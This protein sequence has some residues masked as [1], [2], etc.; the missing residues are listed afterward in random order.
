MINCA[1]VSDRGQAARQIVKNKMAVANSTNGYCQANLLLQPRQR[2]CWIKKLT[3]G[4]NS[5]QCK[6]LPQCKHFDLR[7]FDKP[8][9][10]RPVLRRKITT[11]K[12]LPMMRPKRKIRTTPKSYHKTPPGSKTARERIFRWST[13]G[14]PYNR[15]CWLWCHPPSA[16]N[17][18][19]R[20]YGQLSSAGRLTA[21]FWGQ[22]PSA[23]LYFLPKP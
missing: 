17:Q 6:V 2:A 7:P 11:F 15:R 14:I 9:A 13:W 23:R 18:P 12:K 1:S 21:R 22:T 3:T 4:I 20:I 16:S 19:C 8:R 10:S 5:Y